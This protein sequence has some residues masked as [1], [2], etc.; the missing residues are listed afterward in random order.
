MSTVIVPSVTP[1][2]PDPHVFRE[3]MERVS[4][5]PRVQIDLMDGDFAPNKN[6]NPVQ[7]WWPDGI[8]ADIHLMYDHPVMHV[9]TLISLKPHLII[10]HAEAQTDV[11]ALIVHIKKFG[12]KAGVGLL[13]D[14]SVESAHG[15]IAVADHVL[16]FAGK[17]GSFGGQADLAVLDKISQIRAIRPDIEIG[18]DGGANESNVAQLAEAGVNV[19]DVGGAIQRSERPEAVYNL[20]N[21]LISSY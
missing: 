4:F 20:L 13:A 16:L 14:T 18:W 11:E 15:C 7:V 6:L 3:Q 19:I 5:A 1:N 17:L 12:L 2:T 9:E 8:Q 21:D 10:I